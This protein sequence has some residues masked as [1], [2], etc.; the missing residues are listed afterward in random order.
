MVAFDD[1]AM[2]DAK[3]RSSSPWITLSD[4][5]HKTSQLE[6]A[7]LC[8]KLLLSLLSSLSLSVVAAAAAAAE[9]GSNNADDAG[10]AVALAG[11]DAGAANVL[12]AMLMLVVDSDTCACPTLSL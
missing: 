9:H 2:L 10:F 7:T 8:P 11:A 1:G 12:A 5:Q 4:A 6:G 3:F